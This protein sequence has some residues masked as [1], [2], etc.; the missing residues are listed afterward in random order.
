MGDSASR[1]LGGKPSDDVQPKHSSQSGKE[2]REKE[3]E[4]REGMSFADDSV[5]NMVCSVEGGPEGD[6]N[7]PCCDSY[8]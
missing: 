8:R 7:Q 6:G 2:N 1:R 4:S 3:T 5:S